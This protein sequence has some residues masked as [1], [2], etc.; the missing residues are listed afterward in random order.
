MALKAVKVSTK[1]LNQIHDIT[2]AS[3]DARQEISDAV[4]QAINDLWIKVCKGEVNLL[5]TDDEEF[6]V[7]PKPEFSQD[8]RN[9]LGGTG[10][11]T[12]IQTC[13]SWV[14]ISEG[15][16]RIKDCDCFVPVTWFS[17]V[18]PK[19]TKSASN[20][21][22]IMLAISSLVQSGAILAFFLL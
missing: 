9:K 8:A 2:T 18:E 14:G 4:N 10:P 3:S 11:Y 5:L 16:Y 1:S 15:I 17:K 19:E 22:T 6:L 12:V 13:K 7:Q 20:L 21:I